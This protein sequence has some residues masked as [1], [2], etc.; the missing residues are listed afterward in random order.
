METT[1]S[2][3]TS[4][5][6]VRGGGNFLFTKVFLWRPKGASQCLWVV[7]LMRLVRGRWYII[8]MVGK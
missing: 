1:E 5:G 4:E 7:D 2:I 3:F 8:G 6:R